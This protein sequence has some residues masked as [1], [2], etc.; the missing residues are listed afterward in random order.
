MDEPR[1]H[2]GRGRFGD[3]ASD[4]LIGEHLQELFESTLNSSKIQSVQALN[5][6]EMAVT[7]DVGKEA[8]ARSD[9]EKCIFK[10]PTFPLWGGGWAWGSHSSWLKSLEN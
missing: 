1:D 3:V 5:Q 4:F 6:L 8:A 7:L 10:T 2:H 9:W